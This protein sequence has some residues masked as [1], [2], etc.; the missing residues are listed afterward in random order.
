MLVYGSTSKCWY[1]AKAAKSQQQ[2]QGSREGVN[3]CRGQVGEQVAG[4]TLEN[5]K[6]KTAAQKKGGR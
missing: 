4:R 5:G 1:N 3:A 2:Q 6:S